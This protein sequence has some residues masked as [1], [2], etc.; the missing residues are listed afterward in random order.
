M[1]N[2]GIRDGL[3]S[4]SGLC[5]ISR[6]YKLLRN[7]IDQGLSIEEVDMKLSIFVLSVCKIMMGV[8]SLW[9]TSIIFNSTENQIL[10]SQWYQFFIWLESF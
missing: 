3:N 7:D 1:G 9:V 4:C 6:I 8:V 2:G 10:F 5:P